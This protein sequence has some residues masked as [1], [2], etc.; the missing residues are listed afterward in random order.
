M[1]ITAILSF[2]LPNNLAQ[3]I[4]RENKETQRTS[5]VITLLLRGHFFPVLV[6]ACVITTEPSTELFYSLR[7][8]DD[9]ALTN[10]SE[11]CRTIPNSD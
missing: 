11:Q 4:V 7:H 10:K 2:A 1:G 8:N 9:R 3:A 6:L 5:G